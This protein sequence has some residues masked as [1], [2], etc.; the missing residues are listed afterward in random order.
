MSDTSG[1]P[2]EYTDQDIED[3]LAA[4]GEPVEDRVL[5]MG[6]GAFAWRTIDRE[7]EQLLVEEAVALRSLGAD[8]RTSHRFVG[9]DIVLTVNLQV[10]GGDTV[11]V[12]VV[13][14]GAEPDA[15][16][17]HGPGG[18]LAETDRFEFGTARVAD[19]PRGLIRVGLRSG[20]RTAMTAWMSC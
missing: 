11:S 12:D 16:T 17:V 20:D 5:A 13:I 4:A 9:G 14:D 18:V 8:D 19:V 1:E 3:A 10:T 7:L 15:M 6:I 2:T